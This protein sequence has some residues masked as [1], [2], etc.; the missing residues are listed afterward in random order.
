MIQPV[1]L[2]MVSRVCLQRSDLG[3]AAQVGEISTGLNTMKMC[4]REI[5]SDFTITH[6]K[7]SVKGRRQHRKLKSLVNKL[8]ITKNTRTHVHDFQNHVT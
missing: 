7:L 1:T 3:A 5:I 6:D 4:V 2:L 8:H